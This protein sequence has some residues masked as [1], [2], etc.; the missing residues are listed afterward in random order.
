MIIDTNIEKNIFK[1][2]FK[3]CGFL[4]LEPLDIHDWAFYNTIVS[5]II[6]NFDNI[7]NILY[8]NDN[9][10]ENSIYIYIH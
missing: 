10:I 3:K 4:F 2:L 9:I 8:K 5:P 1:Y 6:N 7:K